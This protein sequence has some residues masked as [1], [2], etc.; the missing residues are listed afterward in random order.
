[1]I[2][3]LNKRCFSLFL[4]WQKIGENEE[5]LAIILMATFGTQNAHSGVGD[6]NIC[7]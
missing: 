4:S 7:S 1:M 2:G 3:P 5:N 6:S